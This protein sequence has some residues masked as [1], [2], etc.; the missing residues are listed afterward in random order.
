VIY[1]DFES[2]LVYI[3]GEE[4]VNGKTHATTEHVPSGFCAYTVCNF[5]EV[6]NA[7]YSRYYTKAVLY[8]GPDAI[9]AFNDHVN[10]ERR[11]ISCLLGKNVA[12]L[13]LTLEQQKEFDDVESCFC[14]GEDFTE[15]NNKVRHHNHVNGQFIAGICSSCN[16]Q[17]KAPKRK[18]WRPLR[19]RVKINVDP[20]YFSDDEEEDDSFFYTMFFPWITKL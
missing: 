19:N 2:C 9:S 10:S 5:A 18:R 17:I 15:T 8:S 6:G 3:V 13:P 1:A 14:C 12:M 4:E 16:L 11:R 20:D 7:D